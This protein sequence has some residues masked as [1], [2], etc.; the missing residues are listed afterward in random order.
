MHHYLPGTLSFTGT[1]QE[2]A[3]LTAVTSNIFDGDDSNNPLTFTY[4]WQLSDTDSFDSSNNI[5]GETSSTFT[6]LSDQ[7]YV[8]KFVRTNC[9]SRR[10]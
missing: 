3:T 4:Q 6:I 7:T 8:D 10:Y 1:V 9:S 5:I 2:G